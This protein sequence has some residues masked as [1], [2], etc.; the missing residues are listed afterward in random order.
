MESSQRQAEN[1]AQRARQQ[2]DTY[3]SYARSESDESRARDYEGSADRC[4]DEARSYESDA[5]R[6]ASEASD[7]RSQIYNLRYC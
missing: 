3:M 2:G 6:Y 1:D 7:L 5:S 4:Y